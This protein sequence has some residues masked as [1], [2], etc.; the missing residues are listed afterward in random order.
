[1]IDRINLNRDI[2]EMVEDL[3]AL[4][5]QNEREAET[6][7]KIFEEKEKAEKEMA[8]IEKQILR[9]QMLTENRVQDMN[10]EMRKR[11]SKLKQAGLQVST[12]ISKFTFFVTN[13]LPDLQPLAGA[14]ERWPQSKGN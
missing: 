1:M 14:L 10:P 8:D 7:E 12:F 9:Q 6:L 3:N 4:K 11:Y 5:V 13:G 2:S